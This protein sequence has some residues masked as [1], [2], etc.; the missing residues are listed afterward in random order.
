MRRILITYLAGVILFL[1]VADYTNAQVYKGAVLDEATR[2]PIPFVTVSLQ[3]EDN[4]HVRHTSTDEDGAFLLVAP[5]MTEYF[6]HVKRIGYS[7][8][9]GGPFLVETGDTLSVQF[10]II[11]L[12][13]FC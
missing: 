4:E 1:L 12:N 6:L 5:E 7:E 3:N 10:R 13:T 2:E 9:S 11:T 8:N